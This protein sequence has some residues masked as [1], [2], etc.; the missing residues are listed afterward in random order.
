[1]PGEYSHWYNMH[2][3]IDTLVDC[4]HSVTLLVSSASPTVP[5]TRKERFD[6]KMFR[7]NIEKDEANAVWSEIINHWMNN[8]ATKYERVLMFW[9]VMSKFMTYGDDVCKAMFYEDFLHT[10]R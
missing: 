2:V 9:R 5:H 6:F 8:T 3:I 7:V 10:L 4:N 1:M